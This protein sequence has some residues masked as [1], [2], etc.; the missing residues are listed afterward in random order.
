[1][2]LQVRGRKGGAVLVALEVAAL[3][4]SGQFFPGNAAGAGQSGYLYAGSAVV[5]RRSK[6]VSTFLVLLFLSKW[7]SR[8]ERIMSKSKE[9][10]NDQSMLRTLSLF[11]CGEVKVRC[12]IEMTL[13]V[14]RNLPVVLEIREAR[15][16]S[17]ISIKVVA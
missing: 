16:D 13:I 3:T 15:R 8:A 1:M 12:G 4:Q 9:C 11:V 7:W 6:L 14:E 17:R 10:E 2:C 5:I